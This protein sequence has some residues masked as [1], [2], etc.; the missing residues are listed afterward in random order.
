MLFLL[1]T[2]WAHVFVI[3]IQCPFVLCVLPKWCAQ[4]KHH[5][6]SSAIQFQVVL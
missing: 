1:Y 2:L 4:S 5:F 6:P 3:V